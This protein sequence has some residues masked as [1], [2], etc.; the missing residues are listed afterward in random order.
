MAQLASSMR[1]PDKV[2]VG[3]SVENAK[4]AS[5]ID[6]LREVKAKVRYT[7]NGGDGS[8]KTKKIKLKRRSGKR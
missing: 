5:R 8:A 6:E 1:V 2:W 4:Y 3:V 7:P